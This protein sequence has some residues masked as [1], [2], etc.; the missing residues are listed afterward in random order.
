MTGYAHGRR[1]EGGEEPAPGQLTNNSCFTRATGVIV[2]CAAIWSYTAISIGANTASFFI[3]GNIIEI[4]KVSIRSADETEETDGS[5][6]NWIAFS[7]IDCYP[8]SSAIISSSN[9]KVPNALVSCL[10][11]KI[12]TGGAAKETKG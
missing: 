3:D 7:G 12:T 10:I 5:F 4:E 2:S 8:V 11:L 9:V 1:I 6:L